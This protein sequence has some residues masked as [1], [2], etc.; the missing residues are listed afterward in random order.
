MKQVGSVTHFYGKAGVAIL[1]LEAPLKVGD[2]I[3]FEGHGADFEQSVESMQM[4][5]ESVS[6]AAA[7][8]QIGIKVDQPVHEG[9]VA[10]LVE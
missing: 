10:S 8:Q 4:D 5:H 6:S 3:K 9:A 7:G 2:R 1:L